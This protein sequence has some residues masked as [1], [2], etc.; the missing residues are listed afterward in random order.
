[1]HWRFWG[2]TNWLWLKHGCSSPNCWKIS[3]KRKLFMQ[4][5]ISGLDQCTTARHSFCM[6]LATDK[7]RADGGGEMFKFHSCLASVVPAPTVSD[8][9]AAWWYLQVFPSKMCRISFQ[10]RGT[11]LTQLINCYQKEQICPCLFHLLNS[12]FPTCKP[13]ELGGLYTLFVVFFF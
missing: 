2:E 3:L 10:V 7:P 1:M 8:T 6:A 4:E 9:S 5:N 12:K 13:R 11:V